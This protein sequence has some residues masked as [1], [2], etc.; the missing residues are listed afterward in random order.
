M[1]D[2]RFKIWND[3]VLFFLAGGTDNLGRIAS[4]NAESRDLAIYHGA[5]SDDYTF[6]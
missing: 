4:D 1:M 2:L 6:S 5:C 3:Q